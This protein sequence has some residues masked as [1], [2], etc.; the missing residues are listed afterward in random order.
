M[1]RYDREIGQLQ[2]AAP[3]DYMC[4]PEM[5]QRTGMKIVEHQTRT[6]ANYLE[7]HM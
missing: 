2:F 4:E 5:L 7:L 1:I 6:V 3:Q